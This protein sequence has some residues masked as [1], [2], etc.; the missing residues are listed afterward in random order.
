MKDVNKVIL[1][2]RLG[3][4]P[5]QRQ[6]KT[7]LAVVNFSLATSRRVLQ[8]EASLSGDPS[9]TPSYSPSYS[10]ETQWHK[11]VVWGKASRGLCAIFKKG[12]AVYMEGSIRSRTYDSKEGGT[13]VSF[14]IYADTVS[15]LGGGRASS[16]IDAKEV[17]AEIPA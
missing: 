2:G 3:A 14:E 7:G 10:E 15:F 12:S 6:T 11:I 9:N 17:P 13:K 4:D 5:I 1:V 16:G 8:E